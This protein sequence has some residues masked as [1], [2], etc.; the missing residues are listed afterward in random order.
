M[1]TTHT[2]HPGDP[3]T[4][5]VEGSYG[6]YDE[7]AFT[8][9]VSGGLDDQFAFSLGTSERYH[10]GFIENLNRPG[11]GTN[12]EDLN[13][14]DYYS[15][16]GE[17]T[18]EP[19]AQLSVVARG[20]YYFQNDRGAMG[21]QPVGL[22]DYVDN[23]TL[24]SLG[25][26]A[27]P[28]IPLNG[29]QAYYAG[30]LGAF[31]VPGAAAEAMAGALQFSNKFGATYDNEANGFASGALRT[32]GM[33]GDFDATQIATGILKV[34]YDFGFA[35]LTSNTSYT[36]STSK[37]ATEII[38][39]NPATYPTGF[40]AGAIGFSGDF[41]AQNWQEDL[42]LSSNDGPVQWIVGANYLDDR[43]LTD[44]TGDLFGFNIQSELNQWHVRSAAA[45]AQATA[46]LDFIA[47]GLSFTGGT[48]YTADSYELR[49][50][51]SFGSFR[52]KIDST[53][54][55]YTARLNYQLEGLL[56]Y[57]GVSTGFK[58]GTLN[59]TNEASPASSRRRSL[60]MKS[61]RNGISPTGCAWTS[62]RSTISIRTSTFR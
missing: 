44:L 24:A 32:G 30:L 28:A 20:S 6:N 39:A 48:R 53:A 10:S 55:T 42:Q 51:P 19:S 13:G 22:K 49:D 1:V 40:G 59:A 7:H 21:L 57:G 29:T 26:P 5:H 58:S 45:F 23:A 12:G 43:G 4:A 31:G 56:L 62:R 3:I 38:A 60:R 35:N 27:D 37:S 50:V 11:V 9:R 36:S 17:L 2:A 18:F 61:A 16:N 25:L 46:P 47:G 15:V 52:N 41:P 14:R 34:S 54:W 33:Q 8:A